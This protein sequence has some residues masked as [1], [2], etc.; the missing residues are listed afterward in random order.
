MKQTLTV[1]VP[2]IECTTQKRIVEMLCDESKSSMK[3]SFKYS[4]P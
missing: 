3:T 2:I 4:S 1:V